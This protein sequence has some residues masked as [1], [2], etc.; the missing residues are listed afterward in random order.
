MSRSNI[1]LA[2]KVLETIHNEQAPV[3]ANALA[4]KLQIPPATLGRMLQSMEYSGYLEKVSNKGRILTA[5]GLEHMRSLHTD[6][7]SMENVAELSKLVASTDKRTMLDMLHVRRLLEAESIELACNRI[8]QDE[9]NEL[10]HIINMQDQEKAAH[11]IG[12]QWDLEFHLRLAQIS[13]NQCIGRIL[14]LLLRQD[15]S[16]VKLSIIA[17]TARNLPHTISHHQIIEALKNRDIP[18]ARKLILHH[19]DFYIQYIEKYY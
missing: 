13:G 4:I 16:Y 7:S 2:Y 11:R 9:L 10:T 17:Q 19:I 5:A 3:G 15:N 8:T 6:L 14:S 18:M 1:E 12:H